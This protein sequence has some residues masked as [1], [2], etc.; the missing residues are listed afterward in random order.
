MGEA[1]NMTHAGLKTFSPVRNAFHF[2]LE[3]AEN[4]HSLSEREK[5]KGERL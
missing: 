4:R 1:L 5:W 2:S 3:Q